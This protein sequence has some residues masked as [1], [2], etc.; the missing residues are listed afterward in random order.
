MGGRQIAREVVGG[1]LSESEGVAFI[2]YASEIGVDSAALAT[3]LLMREINHD[4]LGSLLDREG[5]SPVH[6]DRR[7]S[8]R[9][10]HSGLKERFACHAAK[11][12]VSS[13]AAAAAV[14]RAELRE[15]WLGKC[16]GLHGNQVDSQPD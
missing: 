2:E 11:C 9:A 5:G 6:K 10:K 13:D 15:R 12:G 3:I 7:V 8:A 1:W 4:R 14:F 16:I